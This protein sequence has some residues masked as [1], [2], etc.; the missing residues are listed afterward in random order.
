MS[1]VLVTG[2]S[3]GIGAATARALQADHDLILAGRDTVALE[4]VAR[5]CSSAHVVAGDLT[6]AEGVARVAGGIDS[7]DGLVHSAGIAELGRIDESD[8]A[9]WRRAFEVNVLA[10]VEL[11]RALLPALRAAGG[12]LVVVNSGAGTTAKAGW[13][14]YSASKFALRAVTDTIRGEEPT[15]RVTSI[16]PGRVDTDMQRAIVAREGGAYSPSSYLS[17][18]SVA[19]AVRNALASTPD[20]HP[21]EI[22]LRPRPH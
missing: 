10:V 7:L 16:H 4:A 2:A 15:L 3:R 17:P 11:T 5:H 1:T 19:A 21:T 8:A 20:A 9:Q 13:G 18:D 6:T 14:A 22:V 12:H